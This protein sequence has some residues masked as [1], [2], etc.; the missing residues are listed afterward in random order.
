MENFHVLIV[1]YPNKKMPQSMTPEQIRSVVE[2]A[3]KGSAGMT[4]WQIILLVVV[5]AIA[6]FLGAY[7]QEKAKSTVTKRDIAHVTREIEAVKREL[8]ERGRIAT[9]QYELRYHA[10]LTMLGMIDAHLS[11]TIKKDNQG[12]SIEVDH[13][14]TTVEEARKCHSDL[15]LT[16]N[17][18][19]IPDLFLKMVC[20]QSTNIIIDLNTM[21][22][23]VR[24]ELGFGDNFNQNDEC[25]L[26]Q[27][28]ECIWI[29]T[30]TC[31]KKVASNGSYP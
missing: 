3:V 1:S 21:R 5:T 19:K 6:S 27:N 16:I 25:I 26:N 11:H 10:C 31:K 23:L 18:H 2:A 22:Q 15:L 20:G 12:N 9:K 29:G 8:E 14:Y 28:D 24:K 7:L 13:Q 17:N 4:Y 30:I